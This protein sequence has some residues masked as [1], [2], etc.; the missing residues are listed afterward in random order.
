[1]KTNVLIFP[2]GEVLSVELHDALAT[3]VNINLFGASS[4]NRHGPYIFK[5]YTS[6]LPLIT[7]DNFLDKFNSLLLEKSIDLIFPSHDDVVTFFANNADKIHAKVM[8]PDKETARICRDKALI[9]ETFEGSDFL[10]QIYSTITE[11]PVFIKP[12]ASQGGVGTMLIKKEADIPADIDLNDYVLCEYLPGEEYSVDCLTDKNGRL[13]FVSPRSRNRIMAGITVSGET[14]TL[15]KEIQHIADELNSRLSF[16]GLWFFQIKKDNNEK[17]K[18]LEVAARCASTMGLTRAR[19]VNLPLLSVYIAMGLD[20]SVI[21]NAYNVKMDRTLISRYKI[22]YEFNNVYFDFD[23]TLIINGQV[24][25]YSIMFIYQCQNAGK[26]VFLIT[27]HAKEIYET[28]DKYHIDNNLFAEIIHL[29]VD[30]HKVSK[31][32][33]DRAIFIDNAFSERK[34]VHDE[35]KIPV[36]DVDG[37]EVLLDWRT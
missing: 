24:H 6:G 21:P 15:T 12:R 7:D 13:I 23:D 9:Y 1:M 29:E 20:V 37:I 14:E 27:K 19:G 34:F 26:K 8:A 32:N 30:D 16:L 22:D 18:L 25:P 4:I 5:N 36:F 10:P 2:A 33:P 11:Y 17:W 3:S 31:I 28:L 35:Y